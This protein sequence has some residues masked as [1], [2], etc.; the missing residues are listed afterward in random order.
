MDSGGQVIH[1]CVSRLHNVSYVMQITRAS[2]NFPRVS[3]FGVTSTNLC[4]IYIYIKLKV[5]LKF[6]RFEFAVCSPTS[7]NRLRLGTPWESSRLVLPISSWL[8]ETS[9]DTTACSTNALCTRTLGGW[10]VMRDARSISACH[11]RDFSWTCNRDL[12][13]SLPRSSRG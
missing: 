3:R 1:L 4:F 12:N 8:I 6:A 9:T 2:I 7:K 11:S 13:D 10:F 5:R